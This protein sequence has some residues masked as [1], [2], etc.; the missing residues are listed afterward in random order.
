MKKLAIALLL[1]PSFCYS[2]NLSDTIFNVARVEPVT[3]TS[4]SVLYERAK[5]YYAKFNASKSINET[6]MDPSAATISFYSIFA[7]AAGTVRYKITIQC[8]DGRYRYLLSDFFHSFKSPMGTDISGGFLTNEV[9]VNALRKDTW[10]IIK[11][12]TEANIKTQSIVLND[13]MNGK[14]KETDSNW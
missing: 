3:N 7:V 6:M 5:L 14:T 11:K 2:Q 9:P 1:L 4:A 10:A 12:N 8:K 13:Y